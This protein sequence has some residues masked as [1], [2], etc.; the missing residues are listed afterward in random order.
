MKM[1]R[2]L[3]IK[4]LTFKKIFTSDA[5]IIIITTIVVALCCKDQPID[6]LYNVAVQQGYAPKQPIAYSHQVACR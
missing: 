1:I 5:F 6:G 3:S 4:N 2:S